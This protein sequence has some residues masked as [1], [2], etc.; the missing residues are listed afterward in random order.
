VKEANHQTPHI[1]WLH[2]H[3]ISKEGKSVSKK[4]LIFPKAEAGN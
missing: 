3:E 2:L 4:R 1:A